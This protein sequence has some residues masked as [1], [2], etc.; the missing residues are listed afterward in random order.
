MGQQVQQVTER[1]FDVVLSSLLLIIVIPSLVV[2]SVWIKW[3]SPGPV[4]TRYSRVDSTGREFELYKFRTVPV[5]SQGYR[6]FYAGAYET[7]VGRCLRKLGLNNLP[8]FINVLR[9]D[10]RLREMVE[11]VN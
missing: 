4:F 10:I 3:E 2:T 11:E 8:M 9:G 7:Q 6:S 5:H 1:L